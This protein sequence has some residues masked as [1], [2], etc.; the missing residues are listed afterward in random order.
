MSIDKNVLFNKYIPFDSS[1]PYKSWEIKPV[2]MKDYYDVNIILNIFDIDKNSLGSLEYISMSNL[3]F[4][5]LFLYNQP[6]IAE[7]FDRLLRLTLNI[8]EDMAIKKCLFKDKEY[9]AI[10]KLIGVTR[11]GIPIIDDND[12]RI[13]TPEDFDEIK[14]IIM[15]QNVLDYTDAYID[16]DV[17]KAADEYQRLKNKDVHVSLEHKIICVQMKTGMTK[18]AIGNLSIRNFQQLFDL[19]VEESDYSSLRIA[20][21]NGVKFKKPLEHW[22]YRERKDKY[23]SAFCDADAFTNMVQSAN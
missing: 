19:V 15:F 4:V 11:D 22:A 8:S 17:K 13:I 14:R 5:F 18:E 3:R 1:V 23:A 20:E 9:L 7:A 2:C 6:D 16:P 12:V 10:G 21:A